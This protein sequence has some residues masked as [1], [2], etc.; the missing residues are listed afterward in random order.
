M[1]KLMTGMLACTLITLASCKKDDDDLPTPAGIAGTY[2]LYEVEVYN[3]PSTH[4]L[5]SDDGEHGKIIVTVSSDSTAKV[6]LLLYTNDKVEADTTIN[7]KIGKDQDGDIF[8][9]GAADGSNVAYFFDNEMDFY[10]I[11]NYRLGGRK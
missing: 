1:K 9:T 10:A 2:N 7:C 5:P 11:P 6:Q 8:V 4:A 3:P